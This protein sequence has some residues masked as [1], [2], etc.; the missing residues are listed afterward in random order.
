MGAVE[1]FVSIA[2]PVPGLTKEQ[3]EFRKT[4]IG[5]SE[6]AAIAGL[7]PFTTPL[8]VY[9]SKIGPVEQKPM[10]EAQYWGHIH[11]DNVA[12]EW[13]R[14]MEREG[15]RV[16]HI[17]DDAQLIRHPKYKFVL[18]NT[19]RIVLLEGEEEEDGL[20]CKSANEYVS[21]LWGDED[22]DEVPDYY[23]IQC[24]HYML[25]LNKRRWF[26]AVLIGG[27]RFRK[28]VIQRDEEL[29]AHLITIESQFWKRVEKR[30]P[31][32]PMNLEDIK[33]LYR[34]DNGEPIIATEAVV[35]AVERLRKIK[36]DVKQLEADE[37]TEMFAIK[38]FM[39]ENA[40]LL[41]NSD[42]EKLLT[43]KKNKDSEVFNENRF[44][45]DHP[46]LYK[47]YIETKEGARPVRIAKPKAEKAKAK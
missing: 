14:R 10:T 26:L 25:A 44:S 6:A 1:K 41:L 8:G 3:L 5:G 34:R 15:R 39:G 30:E 31:P 13:V 22:T 2:S 32:S 18:A 20:E 19:D 46:G 29:I 45:E 38:N 21:Y 24:Q 37:A 28:Y 23:L 17:R 40:T 12:Q 35:E 36:A 16:V 9:L 43:W 11:E 4:G 7:S 47:Q 42:G 33:R 27:N